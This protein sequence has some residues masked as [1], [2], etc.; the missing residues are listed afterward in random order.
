MFKTCVIFTSVLFHVRRSSVRFCTWYSGYFQL[1]LHSSCFSLFQH[2]SKFRGVNVD[3]TRTHN[4]Y[5]CSTVCSQARNAH[6][7][8]VH[9]LVANAT[10]EF[11]DDSEDLQEVEGNTVEG[12]LTFP[13]NL[14][15]FPVLA[16]LSRDCRLPLDA[17]NQ[18][19]LQETFVEIN[20]LRLIHLEI[21]F[22]EFHLTMRKPL[23][24]EG[25][26]LFTQV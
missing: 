20:F 15:G 21:I 25:R 12:C 5:L 1:H 14:R 8:L 22:N 17:W 3:R 6:T 11:H 24:P 23:K 7:S 10:A 26:R 4:T 9:Q 19:A 2:V 13:M 18:S 16:M